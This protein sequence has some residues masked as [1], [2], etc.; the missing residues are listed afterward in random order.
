MTIRLA[1]PGD[2]PAMQEIAV[3]A[4]EPYVARMGQEPAPMRPDFVGHIANDT[5]F[6]W[7]DGG[8]RAYAVIIIGE[9]EPLL[10]NIAVDPCAQGQR[11]GSKFLSHI[12][13]YLRDEGFS[14][15][16]LYT[17]V[18]MTENIAWYI[19]AGFT[20]TGCGTQDGFERVFF[21]K[22]F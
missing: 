20:E 5:V 10:D 12:E 21:R 7:D 8:V 13:L 3:L 16:T 18:H 1:R 11:L 4:Y 14:A 22:E 19:R 17:N 15:Y 6:V 2:I 9:H